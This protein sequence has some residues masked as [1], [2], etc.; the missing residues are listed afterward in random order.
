MACTCSGSSLSSAKIRIFGKV[1]VGHEPTQ[2]AP[3]LGGCWE[4]PNL[5]SYGYGLSSINGSPV[6]VHRM[7]YEHFVGPIPTG[8]QIDHLCRNRKCCNP[9][10]LE[11]VTIQ[12]NARRGRDSRTHCKNGHELSG[13]N[14]AWR[15]YKNGQRRSCRK[16]ASE[17]AAK[18]R[19]LYPEREIAYRQTEKAKASARARSRAWRHRRNKQKNNSESDVQ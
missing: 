13:S 1:T 4:Y 11:P 6:L 7:F 17:S 12:E 15:K 16:C 10:H 5:N 2:F 19:L 18:Y 9:A 14:L 3:N 8:L